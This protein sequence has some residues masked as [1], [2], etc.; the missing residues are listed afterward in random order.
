MSAL[1]TRPV[2]GETAPG[3]GPSG[4]ER[5]DAVPG[6]D[7]SSSAGGLDPRAKALFAEAIEKPGGERAEFL[8]RACA[9]P[10]LRAEVESLLCAHD[11]CEK[12]F[13]D[14]AQDPLAELPGQVIGNYKLLQEIG[15]GGFGVVWMAE[16]LEPVRRKVALK[17]LKLGMDTRQ[18]VARFE[19]E[20]Q[21]LAVM[22]HPNVAKGLRRRSD[23]EGA[24]LR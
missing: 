16:Q 10:T 3:S 5:D 8:T 2:Q 19:A 13:G 17:I 6:T 4:A 14:A 1:P 12:S 22:D 21:A 9:D 20:R 15:A 23:R 24:A 18:V 7:G 11:L